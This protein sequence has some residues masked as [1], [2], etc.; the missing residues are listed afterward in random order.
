MLRVQ[1][2]KNHLWWIYWTTGIHGKFLESVPWVNPPQERCWVGVPW[3]GGVWGSGVP[4][5][6]VFVSPGT[7]SSSTTAS[8]LRW[9]SWTVCGRAGAGSPWAKPGSPRA[10][11]SPTPGRPPGTS[12]CTSSWLTETS[13]SCPWLSRS[14]TAWL[15]TTACWS[16]SGKG[17]AEVPQ[18]RV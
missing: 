12:P 6:A 4:C 13:T 5:W 1:A 11:C 10:S 18:L 17:R 2:G 7:R 15:Q 16:S 14:R 3:W 8:P 9:P